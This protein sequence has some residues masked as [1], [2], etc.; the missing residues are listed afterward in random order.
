MSRCVRIAAVA[1]LALILVVQTPSV[2]AATRDRE[3]FSPSFVER[4]IRLVKKVIKP[5]S[6]ASND[7]EGYQITP[8]KP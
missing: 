8:P 2:A 3:V 4:V 7:D 1:L 5:L 6:P